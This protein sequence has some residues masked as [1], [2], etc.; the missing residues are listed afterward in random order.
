MQ[1]LRPGR[2][3]RE[4]PRAG[5]SQTCHQCGLRNLAAG[6]ETRHACVP[7]C[8][9]VG[10]AETNAAININNAVGMPVSGRGDLGLPDPRR[11]NPRTPLNRDAT[12]VAPAFSPGRCSTGSHHP[13][14]AEV[15]ATCRPTHVVRE[16]F[17]TEFD[18]I[19]RRLGETYPL[20]PTLGHPVLRRLGKGN[21]RPSRGPQR[22]PASIRSCLHGMRNPA[23]GRGVRTSSSAPVLRWL[24]YDLNAVT[25]GLSPTLEL[26]PS[27]GPEHARD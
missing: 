22:P 24:T 14:L 11:V 5:T 19:G 15:V 23:V 9:W 17:I 10:H 12:E 3:G 6:G 8:S 7:A 25:A 2:P 18:A 20:N 16:D 27:R 1:D 26:R 4:G 21:D 13:G